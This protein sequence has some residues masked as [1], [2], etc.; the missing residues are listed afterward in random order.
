MALDE[1]RGN[2]HHL[3]T[4]TLNQHMYQKDLLVDLEIMG[5]QQKQKRHPMVGISNPWL[6]PRTI[7]KYGMERCFLKHL[8]KQGHPVKRLTKEHYLE[9]LYHLLGEL[10]Y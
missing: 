4:L 2:Q 9:E 8:T 6:Y 1:V 7:I 5:S 3:Q 10:G